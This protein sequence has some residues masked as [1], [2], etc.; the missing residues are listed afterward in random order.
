MGFLFLYL[1]GPALGISQCGR[2]VQRTLDNSNFYFVRTG[3]VFDLDWH[4]AT[5]LSICFLFSLRPEAS[6]FLLADL[7]LIHPSPPLSAAWLAAVGGRR[8]DYQLHL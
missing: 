6:H 7:K 2:F 1:F 3:E 8:S 5:P 4:N